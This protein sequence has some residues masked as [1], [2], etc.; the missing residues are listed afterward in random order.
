MVPIQKFKEIVGDEF[1]FY[2]EITIQRYSRATLPQSTTPAAVL[3]PYISSE[4]TE[5]IKTAKEHHVGIYPVSRG[6]NWGYGSACAVGDGQVIL[7]LSRMNRIIHVDETLAYAVIEPGV[8]QIQLVAYLK[9]KKIPL[10]LDCSGSG[11]EASIL[12]NTLERGFGHTPYG[13]IFCIPAV[14]RWF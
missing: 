9:E 12:G 11:P 3:K 5:I 8:T 6:C 4:V 10:W 7:D 13:I 1:V 2:D 14:W